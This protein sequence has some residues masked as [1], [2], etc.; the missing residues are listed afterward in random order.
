MKQELGPDESPKLRLLMA[1]NSHCSACNIL[2]SYWNFQLPIPVYSEI[3]GQFN[4]FLKGRECFPHQ[5]STISVTGNFMD[6]LIA[7]FYY[8][9]YYF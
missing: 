3:S 2:P 1:D 9:Y 6:K 8:Y 7:N 5:N 4:I